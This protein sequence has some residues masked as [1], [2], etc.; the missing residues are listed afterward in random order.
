MLSLSIHVFIDW[1]VG[2]IDTEALKLGFLCL[3]WRL[4]LCDICGWMHARRNASTS[5]SIPC[6]HSLST[7]TTTILTWMTMTQ[8]ITKMTLILMRISRLPQSKKKLKTKIFKIIY[9]CIVLV[10]WQRRWWRVVW[11]VIRSV[12][13][14]WWPTFACRHCA[15]LLYTS[16]SPRD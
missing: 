10:H 9:L 3:R 5:R 14:S 1:K 8:T 6:Q 7:Q 11:C 13:W 16:P 12:R 2:Q 15:C 4:I